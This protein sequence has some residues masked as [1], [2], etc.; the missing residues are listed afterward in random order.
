MAIELG[1]TDISMST[2]S[3]ILFVFV[4]IFALMGII[5]FIVGTIVLSSWKKKI[6]TCTERTTG[7]VVEIIE[8]N[9]YSENSSS[10]SSWH[11]VV[12][13]SANGEIIEEESP[14]GSYQSKYVKGQKLSICFNPENHQDFYIE[15]DN[16]A[17]I[18]SK[19]F[20]ISGSGM[21]GIAI[22]LGIIAFI[23]R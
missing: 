9:N 10:T 15:G 20:I 23:V 1:G 21:L 4:G 3:I 5:F 13:F 11:P 12:E 16:V 18:A 2:G 7:K 14:F 19:V 6:K 22:V 8:H 17:K